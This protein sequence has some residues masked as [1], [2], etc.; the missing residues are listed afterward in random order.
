MVVEFS[1]ETI[2]QVYKW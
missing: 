2:E 1:T